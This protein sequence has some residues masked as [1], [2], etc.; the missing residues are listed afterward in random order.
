M[1]GELRG[2]LQALMLKSS[3]WAPWQPPPQFLAAI[4]ERL[5]SSPMAGGFLVSTL[6]SHASHLQLVT[7]ACSGDLSS[8]LN[9]Y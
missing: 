7:T 2:A 4:E 9:L 6:N 5:G 3:K 8:S 1:G